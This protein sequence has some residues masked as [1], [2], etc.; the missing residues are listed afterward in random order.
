MAA[1]L[2]L[3]VLATVCVCVC[4]W[5]GVCVVGTIDD[6]RGGDTCVHE[7][8]LIHGMVYDKSTDRAQLYQSTTFIQVDK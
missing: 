5:V 6:S 7:H 4:A 8:T 2:S 3:C 1:H